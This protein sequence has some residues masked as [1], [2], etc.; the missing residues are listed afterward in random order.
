MPP[1]PAFQRAL[2]LGLIGFPIGHSL[3]PLMHQTALRLAGLAG[4]Y[5]AIEVR[6]EEIPE[7]IRHIRSQEMD[8]FNVTIPHKERIID[9]LDALSDEARTIGAVNTVHRTDGRFTGYNTDVT[10][11]VESLRPYAVELRGQKALILGAGGA[12]RA[13]LFALTRSI[14]IGYVTIA[15]RTRRRAEVIAD[16]VP[17]N[18]IRPEIIDWNAQIL[19]EAVAESA[20]LVNCTPVGMYPDSGHSPLPGSAAIASSLVVFDLVYRP[21]RTALLARAE[22]A[23]CR[24]LSGLDMFIYQGAASFRIWTG[25]PMKIESIRSVLLASLNA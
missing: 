14:G 16:E 4:T 23:G 3:S 19:S 7:W 11:V 12:A 1:A 22:S 25:L 10:G 2:N 13:V 17:G 6:P 21:L 8:G 20:L 9:H 5:R 18:G 15:A 24:T